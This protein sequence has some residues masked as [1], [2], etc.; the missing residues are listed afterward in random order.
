MHGYD[1]FKQISDL[2]GIGIVWH[3]KMGKL[4]SMLHR[5]EDKGWVSSKITQE[6]NRP[7]RTQYEITKDGKTV[8]DNWVKS[9]VASGRDFRITFLL[10]LF[11]SKEKGVTV[12]HELIQNQEDACRNWLNDFEDRLAA[13]TDPEDFRKIVLSFR[14]S[15]INGYIDWLSWCKKQIIVEEK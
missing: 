13:I 6:G 2:S 9:A 5:L 15:Q 11:F 3:V 4:Y 12:A 14:K 8:F 1:L 7:L 10:K